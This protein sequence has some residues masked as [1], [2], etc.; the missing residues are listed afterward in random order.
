M[1]PHRRRWEQ[2]DESEMLAQ[3]RWLTNLPEDQR[4][5]RQ[6]FRPQN[7]PQQLCGP[8]AS[9]T[10]ASSGKTQSS[11]TSR[12]SSPSP[13]VIA[14]DAEADASTLAI[15]LCDI[16]ESEDWIH[17]NVSGDRSWRNNKL[18]TYLDLISITAAARGAESNQIYLFGTGAGAEIALRLLAVQPSR[19]CGVGIFDGS[20]PNLRELFAPAIRLTHRAFLAASTGSLSVRRM[21]ELGRLLHSTGMHVT[22]R[23]CAERSLD[24]GLA[25]TKVLDFVK[26]TQQ[27]IP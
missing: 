20:C 26:W 2:N 13:L 27:P 11:A 14:I 9:V 21:L 23:L 12:P 1:I 18:V 5:R 17:L 16:H 25:V 22:T 19:F 3:T 8:L 15:K 10:E 24:D 7:L 6:A 4:L